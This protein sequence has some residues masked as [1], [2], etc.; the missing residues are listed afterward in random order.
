MWN[1][2]VDYWVCYHMFRSKRMKAFPRV[3][4][5]DL[6]KAGDVTN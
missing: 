5:L 1:R 3:A 2:S 6:Y 4:W